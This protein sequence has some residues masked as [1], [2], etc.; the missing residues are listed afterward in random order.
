MLILTQLTEIQAAPFKRNKKKNK[1]KKENQVDNVQHLPLKKITTKGK[2]TFTYFPTLLD[3]KLILK[4]S[5]NRQVY[6]AWKQ[7]EYYLFSFA[8]LQ[9]QQ[10]EQ[11]LALAQ[12]SLIL[13]NQVLPKLLKQPCRLK[14][15]QAREAHLYSVELKGSGAGSPEQT[16][17]DA[18]MAHTSCDDTTHTGLAW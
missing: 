1:R 13:E 5:S 12:V 10:P 3:Y 17:T 18:V 9:N 4:L 8:A 16:F 6:R 2:K 7:T 15:A 11:S 14:A